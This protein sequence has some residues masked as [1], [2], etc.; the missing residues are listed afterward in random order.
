MVM[1]I[2]LA[3]NGSYNAGTCVQLHKVGTGNA[4]K[5][6]PAH[7]NGRGQAEF[8]AANGHVAIGAAKLADEAGDVAR[9]NPKLV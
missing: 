3:I 1:P 5:C 4:L 8:G 6:L 7:A 9:E 2:R